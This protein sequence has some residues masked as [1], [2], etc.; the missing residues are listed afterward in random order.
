MKARILEGLIKVVTIV[1][2]IAAMVVAIVLYV[3][4]LGLARD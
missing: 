4:S 3:A 1:A 2:F